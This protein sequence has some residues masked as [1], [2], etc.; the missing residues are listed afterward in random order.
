MPSDMVARM[1]NDD[2]IQILINLNGYTKV[3]YC[4]QFICV[5]VYLILLV[6]DYYVFIWIIV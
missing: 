2:Q 4:M 5:I 1:I 6:V 3:F